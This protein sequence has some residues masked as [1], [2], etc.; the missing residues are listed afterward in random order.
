MSWSGTETGLP[1]QKANSCASQVDASQKMSW[2]TSWSDSS[3][4]LSEEVL[5]Y[6]SGNLS[7][8]HLTASQLTVCAA[9]RLTC[10]S[11]LLTD[12]L[13]NAD[14]NRKTVAKL[15]PGSGPVDLWTSQHLPKMCLGCASHG[16]A[17][18]EHA[19]P[20]QGCS[21]QDNH[22]HEPLWGAEQPK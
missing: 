19:L 17:V 20:L 15:G 9:M 4:P 21:S 12:L 18:C 11:K 6:T 7:R 10:R 2:R 3:K 22:K 16:D 1:Q 5:L 14:I 13:A 8:T